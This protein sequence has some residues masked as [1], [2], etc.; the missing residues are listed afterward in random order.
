M[1]IV[2]LCGCQKHHMALANKLSARFDLIGII[3]Q[4]TRGGNFNFSFLDLLNKITDRFLFFPIRKAWTGLIK[5][6][7]NQ[8]SSFPNVDSITVSNINSEESVN[9][10]ISKQPDL[11]MISGTSLIRNSILNLPISKG[12]INLHTGLSPYVKGGPNC[13]NWCIAIKKVHLIGN[14][15]MWIDSGIDSGDIVSTEIT[16]LSGEE[17]FS[18]IHIKV[19]EHAHDLF[20]RSVE[21]IQNNFELCPR[22]KQ[23]SIGEGVTY[24][25]KMWNFSN[26]FH[27]LNNIIFRKYRKFIRSTN[28]AIMKA[29]ITVV[30]LPDTKH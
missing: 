10:I 7:S 6:Y 21:S 9:F 1:R 3:I 30:K 12:I 14:T 29:G 28:N 17:T 18:K 8:Y 22:V 26:K 24:Y 15:V 19:M 23:Q 2:L 20:I 13:T 16:P 25:T 11:L 27:L 4:E 5:Y